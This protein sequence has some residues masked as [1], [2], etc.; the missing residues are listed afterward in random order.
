[1]SG[2]EHR[3]LTTIKRLINDLRDRYPSDFIIK[4]IIQNADDSHSTRLDF[5]WV[6]GLPNAQHPLL[7]GPALFF[8]NN[9]R[10]KRSDAQAIRRF[11]DSEKEGEQTAIGKFG[12]GQKSIFHL[13]EAFFLAHSPNEQFEARFPSCNFLNPWAEPNPQPN[14]QT[15]P[16]HPDWTEFSESDQNAIKAHFNDIL[17][18]ENYQ[19]HFFMLWIPLRKESHR[20]RKTKEGK[21]DEVGVI[22]QNFSGDRETPPDDIFPDN[23]SSEIGLLLPLLRAL[24]AV[25]YWLPDH[26]AKLQPQFNLT[27]QGSRRRYPR[28]NHETP[29]EIEES[30]DGSVQITHFE[31]E[32]KNTTLAFS[33]REVILN[34]STLKDIH[35]HKSWPTS[36]RIDHKTGNPIQEPDKAFAHCAVT[37][38]EKPAT[39]NGHLS[40]QW[41]V[42]LPL[43]VSSESPNEK[44]QTEGDR[45]YVLL[46]HGYFF[47]DA[48]RRHIDPWENS[49]CKLT[50]NATEGE[51]RQK[52]NQLLTTEGTLKNVLPALNLFI[53]T[54]RPAP[55]NIWQL[56]DALKNSAFF[57]QYGNDL[58][59]KSQ[60]VYCYALDEQDWQ[61]QYIDADRPL[62]AIPQAETDKT[63]LLPWDVLPNLESESIREC[64]IT[65]IEAPNLT[66]SLS[67]WSENQ[68]ETVLQDVP[69]NVVFKNKERFE[70]L[71][72]FLEQCVIPLYPNQIL[73][74]MIQ[75][76]LCDIA[77]KAFA[78]LNVNQ[79]YKF[80]EWVT[81]F[82]NFISEK[83]FFI[84]CKTYQPKIFFELHKLETHTIL[85]PRT[86]TFDF[87][88]LQITPKQ[89]LANKEALTLLKSLNSIIQDEKY[90]DIVDDCAAIAWKILCLV[91]DKKALVETHPD[92][93]VLRAHNCRVPQ[94]RT[95][96][97]LKE[98]TTAYQQG[99]LF[100]HKRGSSMRERIG[101]AENLQNVLADATVIVFEKPIETEMADLLGD[102]KHNE[103]VSCEQLGCLRAL[104]RIP[105][106]TL[107]T[108]IEP[109]AKLLQD[110]LDANVE[111]IIF[112]KGIRHL[113]TL[114][115]ESDG[116]EKH[117]LWYL[118]SPEYQ[119]IVEPI[120][121]ARGETAY[122]IDDAFVP[123]VTNKLANEKRVVCGIEEL[124]PIKAIELA[125]S[126]EQP[127]TLCQ[128]ILDILQYVDIDSLSDSEKQELK[129]NLRQKWLVDKKS[130][131]IIPEEVVYL[132]EIK[133]T[134]SR[135]IGE[136]TEQTT[137]R[138]YSR[139][140][141]G[142][143]N[144][145]SFP[146]LC[147]LSCF[148]TG[149][150]GLDI[151][152]L[153]MYQ[154][155]KYHLGQFTNQT[156]P[157][158]S[159]LIVFKNIPAKLLPA[160]E[161]VNTAREKCSPDDI[162]SLLEQ[163]FGQL[164]I[165]QMK[166]LLFWLKTQHINDNTHHLKIRDVFNS[167]LKTAI[168][169]PQF[170]T[171]FQEIY[172]LNKRGK[173][174]LP[175]KLV[176]DAQISDDFLLDS[177]QADILN[178]Y[179]NSH[180]FPATIMAEPAQQTLK[181]DEYFR[182]WEGKIVNDEMIGVFLAL[183]GDA[184]LLADDSNL[185]KLAEEYLQHYNIDDIRTNLTGESEWH[186]AKDFWTHFEIH[187]T[188]HGD[189]KVQLTAL[190][191]SPISAPLC[192]EAQS[193]IISCKAIR[194]DKIS[195]KRL[196]EMQLRIIDTKQYNSTELA[197]LLKESIEK[198][199]ESIHKQK[200]T[201]ALEQ[202]WGKLFQTEQLDID[203]ARRMILENALLSL[204]QLGIKNN[205]DKINS[206]LTNW[207]KTRRREKE[208]GQSKYIKERQKTIEE[209]G[210]VIE[211]DEQTQVAIFEAVRTT[212]KKYQYTP[213]CVPFELFQNADDA[214][215]ELEELGAISEKTK[216]FVLRWDENNLTI[217][218]WGR[219]IN[220]SFFGSKGIERG[221]DRDLEKMLVFSVS[222]KI[223]E[224]TGKFGLGF[225]SVFLISQ[226]P[227]ILSGKDMG[228]KI[229]AGMLP[230]SLNAKEKQNLST[231]LQ[232]WQSDDS[233]EGTIIKLP[234]T[235]DVD[236]V[237]NQVV[238]HFRSVTGILLA[239]SKRIKYCVID[240]PNEQFDVSWQPNEIIKDIS[241]GD[242][243]LKVEQE[244]MSKAL[245]IEN[246][247][248]GA[249]LIAL[250]SKGLCHFPNYQAIPDIWVTAPL[251]ESMK[252]GFAIN[253]R[254]EID[255]GRGRLA[256]DSKDN[257]EMAQKLGYF[258][259]KKL[260]ELFEK[261]KQQ[262]FNFIKEELD[263]ATDI[264][265]YEFWDSVWEIL[266]ESWLN[267][268]H[269]LLM[270][271]LGNWN[272]VGQLINKYPVFPNGL[273]GKYQ[274]LN[275]VK[276]ITY[277]ASG[278]LN[279]ESS[280]THV[281][282]W[283]I[284]QQAIPPEKML[285]DTRRVK[286]EQLIP[287]LF[288]KGRFTTSRFKA[289]YLADAVELEFGSSKEVSPKLAKQLG[290][291]I[292]NEFIN[293]LA[294]QN[295][296]EHDNLLQV[297]GKAYF[298]AQE[299]EYHHVRTVLCEP[300]KTS[301]LQEESH[302]SDLDFFKVLS[303]DYTD[304][305]V[306]FFKACR[307][308][309]EM[310]EL[311]EIAEQLQIPMLQELVIK[312]KKRREQQQNYFELKKNNRQIGENVEL[313]I[314]KIL[315]N[316]GC[317]VQPIYFGGDLEIWPKEYAGWD[318]G[319][320]TISS[321][322]TVE[323]KFTSGS[324]VHLTKFQSKTARLQKSGYIVLVVNGDWGLRELLNVDIDEDSISDK[325]ITAIKDYSHVVKNLYEKLGE[326]P[327]PKE[328]E[329]DL[330]GYWLKNALWENK[331]NI[332][333][334]L[335]NEF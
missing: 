199:L 138:D 27:L 162:Y 84:D 137:Y 130:T 75:N 182:E 43:G 220:K 213:K 286:L 185:P 15:D 45:D 34:N 265:E 316:N 169:H 119:S 96:V 122:L 321:K 299:G 168:V 67:D 47:V 319:Y 240:S 184:P 9:G 330:H 314:K 290:Q 322:I 14:E 99:T 21:E 66:T 145:P 70:Y 200:E 268:D 193:I 125:L 116:E 178:E 158:K 274:V 155:E 205:A 296:A 76:R 227:S 141:H 211:N 202:L 284:F 93:K 325:L 177:R 140:E 283:P 33:G 59:R 253:G 98:I 92:L 78:Q 40:I 196:I 86:P 172:F 181:L 195:K 24:K 180:S 166:D 170:D 303:S 331:E 301:E 264:S 226:Q 46:L 29:L 31:H 280:F 159:G 127:H 110:L 218:H 197:D 224:V 258:I 129:Q 58:C 271:M 222:D 305:A 62:L 171:I 186:N 297:L 194:V 275:T 241:V 272:T 287:E 2:F 20:K 329:P 208:L 160:W 206:I 13:C 173:W 238:D 214:V 25:S 266:A 244:T 65:L 276:N 335:E 94:D 230:I 262:G 22:T 309:Y 118:A 111:D 113:L 123:S 41:A 23:L 320:I 101:F 154:E 69:G 294:K 282:T 56:S 252:L 54:H 191:G 53:E 8:I 144:H 223:G 135:I 51:V 323:I 50:D 28:R 131:A 259:G 204:R 242:L 114:R 245:L 107:N 215:V 237:L 231:D 174:K 289:F 255:V 132:P 277:V 229:A 254:F 300:L 256:R 152:G 142:I 11:G 38:I 156:F 89:K 68:L 5:G 306:I 91:A 49:T 6:S 307:R 203:T 149:R 188:Q 281:S 17:E 164:S 73:P 273:Y 30:L 313:I 117:P 189:G 212:V 105:P 42:F 134:V 293:E 236:N 63:S 176:S 304:E 285:S 239:F 120:L 333:T 79:L 179:L 292:N 190:D 233:L 1:M 326:L 302:Q 102:L 291:L 88:E 77:R 192:Q 124:T 85:I 3:P 167:Y 267:H 72:S 232:Q 82:L 257:S 108:Y 210:K 311:S 298:K 161:V 151:L 249:I 7:N 55:D 270:N 115:V 143:T 95:I 310:A 16:F 71:L 198:L 18:Q 37:F 315:C 317:N 32:E 48:G 74:E 327:N 147:D 235:H 225:K 328:I 104:S 246:Q 251:Q 250:D 247:E 187:S 148:A 10:F 318:I 288:E 112:T 126:Y 103:I 52:W 216:R 83:C 61:W 4:E 157:L 269:P 60:W 260:C 221:F 312:D 201:D 12:L 207:D 243:K 106:L 279:E 228:V 183:L 39:Q 19:E 87:P 80:K 150:D 165:N 133:E 217:M 263:L 332:V 57:R 153:I 324:E 109:R 26:Q 136:Q 261:S 146:K 295:E 121:T 128:N 35:Q 44:V 163:L 334:W 175:S 219:K 248:F 308:Q 97:S 209:L 139:L 64:L 100:H 36:L 278:I 81:K 234:I 90:Q